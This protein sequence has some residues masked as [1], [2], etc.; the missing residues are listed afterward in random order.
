M[1]E[2]N[3]RINDWKEGSESKAAYGRFLLSFFFLFFFLS[4]FFTEF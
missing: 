1:R 2:G 4:F 3:T